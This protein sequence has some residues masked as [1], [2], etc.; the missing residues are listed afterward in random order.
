MKEVRPG[1]LPTN[2]HR[3]SSQG[4]PAGLVRYRLDEEAH[5]YSASIFGVEERTGRVVTRVN[6]NEEPNLK[7]T[8]GRSRPGRQRVGGWK[9]VFCS[10]HPTLM[11]ICV[12]V[13]D[14]LWIRVFLLLDYIMR[15]DSTL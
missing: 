5:P 15:S 13:S 4:T 14:I 6:L 9:A 10:G 1:S 2:S 7:F 11:G 8:V 3:L 12:C